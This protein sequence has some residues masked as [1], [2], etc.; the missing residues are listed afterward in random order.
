LAADHFFDITNNF[1]DWG[2]NSPAP[3]KPKRMVNCRSCGYSGSWDDGQPCP[4]CGLRN[5]SQS[6]SDPFVVKEEVTATGQ[7]AGEITAIR[8]EGEERSVSADVNKEASTIAGSIRAPRRQNEFANQEVCVR[9]LQ[10]MNLDA[11]MSKWTR[12]ECTR[13]KDSRKPDEVDCIAY[14]ADGTETLR[15]QVTRAVKD[16]RFWQPAPGTTMVDRRYNRSIDQAASEIKRAI[17]AKL[18]DA[19]EARKLL[20]ALDALETPGHV[21]QAVVQRIDPVWIASREFKEI[22]LVGLTADLCVRLHP[23]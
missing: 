22:W 10:R 1:L 19:K 7:T 18:Y 2:K 11:G 14:S 16:R 17:G 8:H 6:L 15:I 5:I 12:C 21:L 20:L 23:R 9:L 4:Q 3:G 13:K